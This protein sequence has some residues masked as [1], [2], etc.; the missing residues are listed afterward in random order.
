M[1][2]Q[3]RN[4][5]QRLSRW[6]NVSQVS[7]VWNIPR[8]C[9]AVSLGRPESAAHTTDS[10]G[11]SKAS[12]RVGGSDHNLTLRRCF[13]RTRCDCRYNRYSSPGLL[14]RYGGVF[15][16]SANVAGIGRQISIL[17]SGYQMS[18]DMGW[19]LTSGCR[20]R[21][22]RRRCRMLRHWMLCSVFPRI[23][24]SISGHLAICTY[25]RQSST[26]RTHRRTALF[27]IGGAIHV[28]SSRPSAAD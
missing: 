9:I 26:D 27:V 5:I 22:D 21:L 2:F 15:L 7:R 11:K 18:A 8:A 16:R 17:T 6:C 20:V 14:G 28:V 4:I 24:C 25:F 10:A 12:A 3:W 13:N 23:C 1:S 19:Q